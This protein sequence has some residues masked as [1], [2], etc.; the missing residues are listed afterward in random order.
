MQLLLA[1]TVAQDLLGCLQAVGAQA[2]GILWLPG[3]NQQSPS[4]KIP[5]GGEITC[6][7]E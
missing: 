1:K 6:V 7:E 3:G 4:P 5:Q 2:V